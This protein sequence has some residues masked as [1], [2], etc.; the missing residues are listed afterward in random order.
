MFIFP[1]ALITH[2]YHHFIRTL[3]ETKSVYVFRVRRINARF[4]ARLSRD[5]G[6]P[7]PPQ[8]AA[9]PERR[10]PLFFGF[11]SYS[12]VTFK[13]WKRLGDR[14][15]KRDRRLAGPAAGRSP[16]WADGAARDLR[17]SVA[18]A[19]LRAGAQRRAE[20]RSRLFSSP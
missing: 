13:L 7:S 16:T 15:L 1:S 17:C 3:S 4:P 2:N 11:L 8:R 14:P 9:D 20:G 12:F 6:S 19:A 18:V 10:K 5:R